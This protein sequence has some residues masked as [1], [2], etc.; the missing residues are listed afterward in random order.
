MVAPPNQGVVTGKLFTQVILIKALLFIG[1]QVALADKILFSLYLVALLLK[2][3]PTIL[4]LVGGVGELGISPPLNKKI[5]K[6]IQ[7]QYKF[8]K[9]CSS[10]ILMHL[11]TIN[12]SALIF[13]LLQYHTL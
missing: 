9:I 1:G 11:L 5:K 7:C 4:Q 6:I 13:F 12:V 8:L 10:V 2:Y 3:F